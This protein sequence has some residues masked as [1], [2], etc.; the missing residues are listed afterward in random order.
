M[1]AEHKT[2]DKNERTF[3]Q[4]QQEIEDAR[5]AKIARQHQTMGKLVGVFTARQLKDMMDNGEI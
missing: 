4:F 2:S 3:E 1:K 5:I